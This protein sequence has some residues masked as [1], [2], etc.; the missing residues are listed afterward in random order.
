MQLRKKLPV[1]LCEEVGKPQWRLDVGVLVSVLQGVA[2]PRCG[3]WAPGGAL[4]RRKL[5]VL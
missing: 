1:V 5:A 3:T 2:L 4:F